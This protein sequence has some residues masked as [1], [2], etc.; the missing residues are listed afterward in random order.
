MHVLANRPE[1]VAD[2]FYL[3]NFIDVESKVDIKF[4]LWTLV[5]Y[6]YRVFIKYCFFSLK[7]CDFSELCHFCCSAGVLPAWYV[8]TEKGQS[9]E[10]F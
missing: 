2:D 6:T 9:P 8:Y 1:F 5:E 7:F 4:I 10:I 3:W